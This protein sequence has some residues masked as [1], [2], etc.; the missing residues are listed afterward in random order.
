MF[1]LEET[2]ETACTKRSI[3]NAIVHAADRKGEDALIATSGAPMEKSIDAKTLQDNSTMR[4]H[5]A[6]IPSKRASP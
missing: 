3:P 6:S 1:S 5:S 2:L 4:L